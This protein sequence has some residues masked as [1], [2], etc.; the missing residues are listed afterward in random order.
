MLSWGLPILGLAVTVPEL[1]RLAGLPN[2]DPVLAALA[3]V[4]TLAFAARI[5]FLARPFLRR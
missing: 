1:V 4:L 3:V 5:L 2:P